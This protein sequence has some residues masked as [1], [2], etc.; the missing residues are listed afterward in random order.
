MNT[1]RNYRTG[2]KVSLTDAV[3]ND[4]PIKGFVEERLL[5]ALLKAVAAAGISADDITVQSWFRHDSY[6][7]VGGLV[8]HCS[9]A[10]RL[11]HWLQAWTDVQYRSSS[12]C[13]DWNS[14]YCLAVEHTDAREVWMKTSSFNIGD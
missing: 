12:R 3:R 4:G 10:H 11:S 8:F 1:A 2:E 7:D 13:T 14:Y 5:P 9:D 6:A